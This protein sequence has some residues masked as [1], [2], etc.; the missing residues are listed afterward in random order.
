M[1]RDIP[2]MLA[3]IL[4]CRDVI[5]TNIKKPGKVEPTSQTI[6]AWRDYQFR[7][8]GDRSLYAQ[9]AAAQLGVSG[10]NAPPVAEASPAHAFFRGTRAQPVGDE[11]VDASNLV[12]PSLDPQEELET[13][14]EYARRLQDESIIVPRSAVA[15]A[16]SIDDASAPPK[17]PPG[18]KTRKVLARAKNSSGANPA[19]NVPP[20]VKAQS[21]LPEEKSTAEP[22]MMQ[23]E[24]GILIDLSEDTPVIVPRK[25]IKT[26]AKSNEIREKNLLGIDTAKSS[27]L[28]LVDVSLPASY[29]SSSPILGMDDKLPVGQQP[30]TARDIGVTCT[31]DRTIEHPCLDLNVSSCISEMSPST[32][33]V[34]MDF[35]VST[36]E[37][38]EIQDNNICLGFYYRDQAFAKVSQ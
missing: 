22:Q 33:Q 5:A 25:E 9:L 23:P 14:S 7:E 36:F 13:S 24:S 8:I 17:L 31:E 6:R 34:Q 20:K 30:N 26:T 27:A 19:S 21:S 37:P 11:N 35:Q 1:V 18:I 32:S 15:P 12:W 38:H 29:K 4:C 2:G 3:P 16:D 10:K 28:P